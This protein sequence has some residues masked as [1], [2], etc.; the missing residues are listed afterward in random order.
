MMKAE[1]RSYLVCHSR[2][3]SIV[4]LEK[5]EGGNLKIPEKTLDDKDL[6]LTFTYMLS[7][8]FIPSK[9]RPVA[10]TCLVAEVKASL[11]YSFLLPIILVFP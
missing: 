7:G 2:G 1:R 10:I 4:A 9:F 5:L 11:E 8:A 3:L 6:L